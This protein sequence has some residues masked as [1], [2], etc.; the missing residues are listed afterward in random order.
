[1]DTLQTNM[2]TITRNVARMNTTFASMNQTLDVI[3]SDVGRM[4]APMRMFNWMN[5]AN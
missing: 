4:S 5:P 1:M 3:G 2:G